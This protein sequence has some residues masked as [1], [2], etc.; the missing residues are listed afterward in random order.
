LNG[1]LLQ[2]S[3]SQSKG[4]AW[5]DLVHGT[6]CWRDQLPL[7]FQLWLHSRHE[8]DILNERQPPFFDQTRKK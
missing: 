8:S 7:D 3:L 5:L 1:R 2:L 6:S 4:V